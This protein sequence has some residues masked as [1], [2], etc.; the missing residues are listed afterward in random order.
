MSHNAPP[1]RPALLPWILLFSACSDFAPG[2][3]AAPTRITAPPA[4]VTNLSAAAYGDLDGDG[5][6]DLVTTAGAP[7]YNDGAGAFTAGVIAWHGTV[8]APFTRMG[9]VT[10][11]DLNGDGA[12][13]VV[14]TWTTYDATELDTG[15][16]F[17]TL[18]TVVAVAYGGAGG[19]TDGQPL[20]GDW[21]S[22][23]ALRRVGDTDG[24]GADE[25]AAYIGGDLWA[26]FDTTHRYSGYTHGE[27]GRF[28][29]VGD[30]NGDGLD[31][32]AFGQVVINNLP[33]RDVVWQAGASAGPAPREGL[34]AFGPAY[35]DTTHAILADWTWTGDGVTTSTQRGRQIV[36][37]GDLDG[38]GLGDLVVLDLAGGYQLTWLHGRAAVD[39]GGFE[40]RGAMVASASDFLGSA[41]F[42][43]ADLDGD[44]VREVVASALIHDQLMLLVFEPTPGV[45][46]PERI[47]D[48]T[49]VASYTLTS[50]QSPGDL[51]GDGADD[52]I[53]NGW[54]VYGGDVACPGTRAWYLDTDGD[55]HASDAHVVWTCT[56]PP[57][58]SAT[59]GDDCDDDNTWA[60]PG[61]VEYAG[62]DDL[63]CD[64]SVVCYADDDGDTYGGAP[65]A[66]A[67]F[68][69]SSALPRGWLDCDDNDASAHP[70]GRE[71]VANDVDEDC[72][73]ALTCYEDEDQDGLGYG[74]YVE[75]W[76]T[77]TCDAAINALAND[78]DDCD[79]HDPTR[80]VVVRGWLDRDQD[81][82]GSTAA[83]GCEA[84]PSLALVSGDCND[85]DAATSPGHVE[86]VGFGDENCDGWF[87][88]YRDDD[89]DGTGS[90][91]Y[92][93][94]RVSYNA[95]T[96]SDF[97]YLA[98][99]GGDCDDRNLAVQAAPPGP[100]RWLDLDGDS[101]GGS[102][103]AP[104]GG[105]GTSP[106]AGDCDD[107]NRTI[108][109]G[110]SEPVD[111]RDHNCDGLLACYLDLDGDRHYDPTYTVA[112]LTC[113]TWDGGD[114]DDTEPE[115]YNGHPE[116]NG[117]GL[118]N[119][120][121]GGDGPWLA[122]EPIDDAGL[123]RLA[124]TVT[125]F[126]AHEMVHYLASTRGPGAGP[127]AP[128]VADCAGIL[129]PRQVY[130]GRLQANFTEATIWTPPV[131]VRSGTPIWLQAISETTHSQVVRYVIP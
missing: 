66:F 115:V 12:G 78:A 130:V 5:D 21:S 88:C 59:P 121:I 74:S 2:T 101:W 54:V 119:N 89:R 112:L 52:L 122:V 114:C 8:Q 117:D 106:A 86:T 24:D 28:A 128:F 49:G 29:A 91:L 60:H 83:R 56:A 25:V 116:I 131:P 1:P 85:L 51:D 109:P 68:R 100:P 30:T 9:A 37:P 19:A 17:P 97:S 10:V 124:L 13:D 64:G 96:C 79:D 118:D 15:A 105:A 7:L 99:I 104:C 102:T 77:G 111:G 48:L 93:G 113:Q 70:G 62:G 72:N 63:A 82:Y 129:S 71:V 98:D 16:P 61:A 41:L 23:T 120:C 4:R 39:G 103:P 58:A 50:L 126:P 127:C 27:L 6:L 76:A 38:D 125:D 34:S 81:G 43:G 87:D 18:V 92:P 32:V 44:G 3:A 90:G 108:Y 42:V 94:I 75:S 123:L 40:A 53:V 26:L 11:A 73:G 33:V 65:R 35:P 69:C 107:T 20:S 84:G 95:H 45:V 46:R 55:G 31:D 22:A 14:G 57:G 47:L 80:G 67:G 36:G 110:A